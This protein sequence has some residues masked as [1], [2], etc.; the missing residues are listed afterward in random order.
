MWRGDE[1]FLFSS[2]VFLKGKPVG[3]QGQ[4]RRD[5][6]VYKCVIYGKN[7]INQTSA[8]KKK[9]RRKKILKTLK[10]GTLSKHCLNCLGITL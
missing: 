2:T 8:V 4:W 3:N 6:C 10:G 1:V 5:V 9:K 7:E